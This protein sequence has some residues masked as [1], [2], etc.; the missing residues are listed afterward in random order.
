M[1]T[2]VQIPRRN[3]S[4]GGGFSLALARK[5]IKKSLP[6]YVLI[7]LPL[8][9]LL[10]FK[11]QPIYG[12]QIAF[13][14][15]KPRLGF[16]GSPWVSLKYFEMFLNAPSAW[17]ILRNTFTI[18]L[19]SLLA[20]FPIPILL[21][22]C[23]N[24]VRVRSAKKT[25]QMI[26]Y[27]P[28]FISTVVLV[29]MINQFTD[30][31]S[32]IIN[33]LFKSLGGTPVNLMGEIAYFRHVYVWTGV[34]QTAGY[35]AVVYI[36]ALSG[37]SA[38][39]YDAA[40]VDGTSKIQRIWH[41]DLPGILPTIITLFVLNTGHILS[42]GFEKV[43]LMQS[44]INLPQSEVISTYVYKLGVQNGNF[45]TSAAVGLFNSVINFAMLVLC[46]TASRKITDVGVW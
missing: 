22:I 11:Y 34:W 24:E 26:T 21:A 44:S 28:Y 13:R 19:Y 17:N 39:L 23:V 38:E 40:L 16:L 46:N 2:P 37:V 8:A 29:A 32:G 7:L 41:I 5:K 18:S 1:N 12:V 33:T 4:V 30:L 20:G 14:D 10:V 15:Y 43:Y 6:Y 27:M 35:S 42:V 36:A 3:A 9:Y 25:V 31:H 45:S